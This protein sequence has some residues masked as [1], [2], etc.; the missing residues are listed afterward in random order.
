MRSTGESYVTPWPSPQQRFGITILATIIDDYQIEPYVIA[1][2]LISIHHVD[3][4]ERTFSHLLEDVPLNVRE[5][6]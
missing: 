4:L 3:L 2:S 1:N 5:G 6:M